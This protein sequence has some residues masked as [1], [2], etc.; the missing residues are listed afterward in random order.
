MDISTEELELYEIW[1][2]GKSF[3]DT[4][5]LNNVIDD[6]LKRKPEPDECVSNKDG[7]YLKRWYLVRDHGVKNVYL[8]NFVGNDDDRALHDHPWDSV[9]VVLKGK[10]KEYMEDDYTAIRRQGDVLFRNADFAHRIELINGPAW[11]LF[12]TGPKVRDWGFLCEEGWT[13]WEDFVNKGGC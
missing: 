1:A 13:H 4:N 6:V 9:S 3:L 11:T 8:H 12:I 2:G 10:Y 5:F 7:T